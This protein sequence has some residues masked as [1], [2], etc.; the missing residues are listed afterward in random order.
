VREVLDN[1]VIARLE[2]LERENRKLK[3]IGAIAI[4]LSGALL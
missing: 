2:R 3:R 4:L 1:E